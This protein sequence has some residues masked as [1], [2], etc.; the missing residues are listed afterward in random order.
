M[1]YSRVKIKPLSANV[2]WQGKRF[3][4]RDYKSYESQMLWM[5]PAMNLSEPPYEVEYRF[6]LSSKN[7][8][9]DNP[10]KPFQD[11][12]QKKYG[13]NDKDIFRA[14]VEKEIVPKGKEYIEFEIR[15]LSCAKR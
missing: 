3:K 13:F 7:A 8:D 14:V 15:E 2:C 9:W 11:I 12:L 6:G 1:G 5:L 10:I 4:T